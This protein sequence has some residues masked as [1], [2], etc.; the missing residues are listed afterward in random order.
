MEPRKPIKS[1]KKS[2]TTGLS[3]VRESLELLNK[4]EDAKLT[5]TKCIDTL[6]E[7]SKTLA[8]NPQADRFK[9]PKYSS[10]DDIHK[11]NAVREANEG[12]IHEGTTFRSQSF[13]EIEKVASTLSSNT[14]PKEALQICGILEA[15]F[16]ENPQASFLEDAKL[17]ILDR[18][19]YDPK[20]YFN[21]GNPSLKAPKFSVTSS[22]IYS[23]PKDENA[24]PAPKKPREDKEAIPL[25]PIKHNK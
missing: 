18:D 23:K 25:T 14:T 8:D 5:L 10:L 11:D 2:L 1:D 13:I 16:H 20:P 9:T 17:D 7:I 15:A 24:E 12:K 3:E 22:P 4:N 19:V 21:E 6:K